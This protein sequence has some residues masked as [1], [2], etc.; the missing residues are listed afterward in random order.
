MLLSPT[1]ASDKQSRA[2]ETF[3][4]GKKYPLPDNPPVALQHSS[5]SGPVLLPASVFMS[6]FKH[7]QCIVNPPFTFSWAPL[8]LQPS[9]PSPGP[10]SLTSVRAQPAALFNT[11]IMAHL[12]LLLLQIASSQSRLSSSYKSG[13][14]TEAK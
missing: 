14:V 3:L 5:P 8:L 7:C 9:P 10:P 4:E 1:G 12:T 2:L 11:K 13:R 6:L